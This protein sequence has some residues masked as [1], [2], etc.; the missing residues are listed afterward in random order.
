MTDEEP[1]DGIVVKME[2]PL[3]VNPLSVGSSRGEEAQVC[4]ICGDKATGKHYGAISCDGCKGFFRRTV[5]K[6]HNYVCRYSHTCKVDKDHRNTCRRCRF[7]V[8]MKMGMR[9]EAVQAERDRIAKPSPAATVAEEPL[10]EELLQAEAAVR[11]LRSS[12]ITRTS[13]ARHGEATTID[14]TD[15]MHQQLVLMV[16]WAKRL[17]SFAKLPM[18]AQ[19]GLLRHFSAQHLVMCAAFRSIPLDDAVWLTNETRLH[20]NSKDVPD[21]NR[22]AARIV[23]QLTV[24][25]RRLEMNEI[26]YCALKAVAFFDP[27]AKGVDDSCGDVDLTRQQV[28]D[29]FERHVR[30]VSPLRENPR[31]FSQ[32]L[33][34]LPPILGIARDLIEDVQLAKLFGLASI[35]RLMAELM[36]PGESVHEDG[37]NGVDGSPMNGGIGAASLNNFSTNHPSQPSYHCHS[38]ESPN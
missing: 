32:F 17:A 6:R 24:P 1:M 16:E 5:R 26:E 37:K 33:L 18:S 30:F 19:V 38:S 25:M 29:A 3:S 11:Q 20:K 23:D 7:D 31:R 9:K 27:I 14:V 21:M 28:L 22:V 12:V 15:S 34:L 35:D 36:L 13:D 8:C 10:L 2:D 4:A